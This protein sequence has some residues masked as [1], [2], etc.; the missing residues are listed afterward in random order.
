MLL[1]LGSS[2]VHKILTPSPV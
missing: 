2:P 1:A